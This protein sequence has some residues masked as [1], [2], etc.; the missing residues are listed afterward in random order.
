MYQ[1]KAKVLRVVDGDTIDVQ[2]D[3]GFDIIT[4]RRIR[5]IAEN[6]PYFDTPETWRPRNEAEK[7][8]GLQATKRAEEL[9]LDKIIILESLKQGKFNY[10]AKVKLENNLDYGDLMINEGFLKR[11]NY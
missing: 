11:E 6:H 4:N 8:H 2:I 1:Y 10:V 3:L 5:I 9:I 7:E